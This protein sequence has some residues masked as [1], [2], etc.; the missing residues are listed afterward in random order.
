MTSELFSAFFSEL[1]KLAWGGTYYHGTSPTA[2]KSILQQGLKTSYGGTG[3]TAGADRINTASG[4]KMSPIVNNFKKNTQGQVTMSRSKT[5]AK[6]Y[7]AV[8]DPKAQRNLINS[9]ASLRSQLRSPGSPVEKLKAMADAGRTVANEIQKQQ[10]LE[11]AG[12]GLSGL[13]RDPDH[14]LLGVQSSKNIAPSL[15]KKS[16]PGTGLLER[17]G[18][19]LRRAV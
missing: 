9:A 13:R 8:N 15:I 4:G 19:Y 1:E 2:E 12:K 5:L 14:L 11:I 16:L 17:A 3:T 6:V 7:G 18:T 10:P